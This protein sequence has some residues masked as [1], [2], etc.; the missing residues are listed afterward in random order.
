MGLI[1]DGKG[2]NAPEYQ[3][4]L[5]KY[6]DQ[7][8]HS[9]VDATLALDVENVFLDFDEKNRHR[10][11]LLLLGHP[12][13]L[14]G[15]FPC[16]VSQVQYKGQLDRMMIAYRYELSRE[17]IAKLALKGVYDENFQIPS[18]MSDNRYELPCKANCAVL[19]AEQPGLPP[20]VFVS[21]EAGSLSAND[22]TSGYE[23]DSYF[24]IAPEV[25]M[26]EPEVQEV[27]EDVFAKTLADKTEAFEDV[28]SESRDKTELETSETP[29]VEDGNP[30]PGEKKP[31]PV[32]RG[33]DVSGIPTPSHE[34]DDTEF[35]I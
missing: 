17:N 1:L 21:P 10:P 32:K 25:G 9:Q 28:L 27:V 15:E 13:G 14:S 6:S 29:Q 11:Y 4:M 26:T 3:V 19:P 31:D 16:G 8:V 30:A 35:V 12:A 7:M 23:I 5:G 20:V 18:I 33:R 34:V 2:L 24:D 22:E